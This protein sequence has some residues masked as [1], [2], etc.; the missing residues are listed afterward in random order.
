MDRFRELETFVAVADAG[1]FSAAAARLH[2]SPPA[3]TRIVAALEDRLG[4]RLL[5][6]TTRRL[7]LTDAGR[8]HLEASR[9][10]L[11]DLAAAE[12][13][14]TGEAAAPTGHLTVTGSVTFGRMALAPVA[15]AF[16]AAYPDVTLSL[17]LFDRVTDL[18]DE[19]IDAGIRLGDLPDSSL[20]ARRVGTVRRMLVAAP[21]YLRR[22]GAPAA[23]AD[24]RDHAVI[25]FTSLMANREWRYAD[26][27]TARSIGLHPRFEV[28]DATAA[29]AAAA[30]GD[31]IT[32]AL[33]YMVA[34]GV[35]DGT[36]VPVLD[37]YAPSDMPV[38]IVFPQSRLVA[39]KI[40]AFVDFAAPRLAER[41]QALD[42]PRQAAAAG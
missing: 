34:Q 29:I 40:R 9:R 27:G 41:L 32:L 7:S 33:S 21:G 13:D 22:H 3:V 36:L 42:V 38:H 8:R 39:P 26:G 25:G 5:N 24:L 11:A 16:L 14:T 28:N 4:I 18:I 31:G 12:R 1:S 15:R 2:A 6:R 20:V 37:G 30:A 23:P 17:R 35:R 19:G 10:I